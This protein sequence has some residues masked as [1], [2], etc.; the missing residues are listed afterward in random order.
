[1]QHTDKD[2]LNTENHPP[3]FL[4]GYEEKWRWCLDVD[5]ILKVVD[6]QLL[7]YTYSTSDNQHTCSSAAS[8]ARSLFLYL[9]KD[10]V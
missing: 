6:K 4:W 5:V 8:M 10:Q 9:N 1:M 7:K 3:G 2:G